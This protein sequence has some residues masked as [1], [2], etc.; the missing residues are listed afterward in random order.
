[1]TLLMFLLGLALG[2]G[3]G[4][5]QRH[6]LQRQLLKILG[7]LHT[8]PISSSM[9]VVS[10]LRQEVNLANQYREAQQS[11]LQTRKQ[12]LDVMP[13]GYLLLD[14][15]NQ[16]LECNQLAR[17]LLHIHRWEPE[18]VR[19]LLEVVRSYELDQL[20]ENTRMTQQQEIY[21]WVFHPVCM[22]GAAMGELR[23]LILRASSWPL[24]DG[25]VG[26]FLENLQPFME[27]KQSRNQWFSNL[28][29]E[30][31]T[32]LTSVRLVA[33]ALRGSLEPTAKRWVEQMLRETDRLINL[34]EDWLELSQ[35][36]KDPSTILRYQTVELGS[37]VQLVWQT[38]APLAEQ[39]QI[40]LSYY[41]PEVICLEADQSRLIQV[42]LNLLDNSIKHSLSTSAVR[43]E[44]HRITNTSMDVN[45]WSP[46]SSELMVNSL[47]QAGALASNSIINE[48]VKTPCIQIDIIDSG[49]GFS[50]SDLPHVFER[51]YKGDASRQK[52]Q[53]DSEASGAFLPSRGSGLGLSIV[54]QIIQAHG[55]TIEARNH[56]EIGGAWLQ[57]KLPER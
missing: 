25:E 16:L 41:E 24:A 23:P 12:L 38:L 15:E 36:E 45:S 3:I 39:K 22:D 17:Q 33:E 35:M 30:L 51:L 4:L 27:L 29:H 52:V 57:I 18:K 14:A 37:L 47:D 20:I 42:F 44:A 1:M 56:P 40:S 2:I 9:R 32:P 50:P 13:V 26:V 6:L 43:V 7:S 46:T 5:W 21:E 28:A 34:V 19:L 53:T 48:A 10:R 54:Q 49:S 31:K 55:G 8:D 11:A